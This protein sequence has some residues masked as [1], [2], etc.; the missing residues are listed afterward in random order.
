M[1]I[2]NLLG[3]DEQNIETKSDNMKKKRFKSLLETQVEQLE[4]S[5]LQSHLFESFVEVFSSSLEVP[6]SSSFCVYIYIL[7]THTHTHPPV[8]QCLHLSFEHPN[9]ATL[10]CV[11]LFANS[12]LHWHKTHLD[13]I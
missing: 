5:N 2:Y 6:A 1:E 7:C 13:A 3:M 10:H 11:L 12:I 8:Y 4:L 9:L